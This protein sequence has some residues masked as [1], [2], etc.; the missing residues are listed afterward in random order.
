MCKEIDQQLEKYFKNKACNGY[1]ES[2]ASVVI[3]NGSGFAV[4]QKVKR[5]SWQTPIPPLID[6]MENAFDLL[7]D[8][9]YEVLITEYCDQ[10][11]QVLKAVKL[12]IAISSYRNSLL[13]ARR[14]ISRFIDKAV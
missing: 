11:D 1:K 5:L 7:S 12:D 13:A 8:R 14:K 10:G 4:K 6:Q 2:F 3:G 9:E